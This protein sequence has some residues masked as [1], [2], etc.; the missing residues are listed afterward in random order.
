MP[1]DNSKLINVYLDLDGLCNLRCLYCVED[2]TPPKNN[3]YLKTISEI[4]NKI[5]FIH[6]YRISTNYSSNEPFYNIDLLTKISNYFYIKCLLDNCH[7]R[8]LCATNGTLLGNARVQDFLIKYKKFIKMYLSLDGWKDVQDINRP[9][10]WDKIME[11]WKFLQE[12]TNNNI[13][14]NIVFYKKTAKIACI[15]IKKLLSVLP[16]I[17]SINIIPDKNCLEK[18]FYELYFKTIEDIGIFILNKQLNIKILQLNTIA[19]QSVRGQCNSIYITKDNK[20]FNCNTRTA[21]KNK[22]MYK[23]PFDFKNDR[24]IIDKC[25]NC[26]YDYRYCKISDEKKTL[27]PC[28]IS[29]Q[30]NNI[31]TKLGIS[32]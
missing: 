27:L 23:T 24:Y 9:N 4:F 17:S 19:D 25:I 14:L 22:S 11:N 15:S 18:N 2:K 30:C 10:S 13:D 8:F 16:G 31:R 12:Y 28:E 29:F 26:K 21:L 32:L 6:D 7:F 1:K 5:D 3:N 20:I